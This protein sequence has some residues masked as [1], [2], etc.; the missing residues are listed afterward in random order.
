MTITT[1]REVKLEISIDEAKALRKMLI[2]LDRN[3]LTMQEADTRESL[4]SIL[5]GV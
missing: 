2:D 5:R 1:R 3:R 4:I